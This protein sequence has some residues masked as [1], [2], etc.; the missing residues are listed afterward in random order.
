MAIKANPNQLGMLGQSV[1]PEREIPLDPALAHQFA[2]PLTEQPYP[3]ISI[4]ERRL[5]L[6]EA[7][8]TL[9]VY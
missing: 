1:Y 3:A 6:L 7:I 2:T 9:G 8:N 4:K 5:N